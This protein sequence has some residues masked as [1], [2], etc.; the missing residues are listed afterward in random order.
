MCCRCGKIY[1][2]TPAGKHSSRE[3]C[4][5]HLGRLCYTAKGLE[6]T[7]VTVVDPSLQ[8]V[9]DTFVKPDEEVIDYNTRFSGAVE[10][11]LKDTKT[12]IRDVQAT[13]LNLFSADTVLIGHSFEH[14]LYA[15]KVI[16]TSVVDTTVMF[17]HQL[18][19]PHKR[20]FKSLVADYLWR[21][22]QDDGKSLLVHD[23][24]RDPKSDLSKS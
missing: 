17:P 21:I 11:D 4:H 10:D 2:M 15:L 23:K 18:D 9:Y 7:Q 13:L 20:S 5:Y 8:V 22:I 24:Y 1:G 16:H 19:L 3:E 12:S 6:L 14:S